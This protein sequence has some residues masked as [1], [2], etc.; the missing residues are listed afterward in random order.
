MS[1]DPKRPERVKRFK[2]I[3]LIEAPSYGEHIN[4]VG[5]ILSLVGLLMRVMLYIVL[6]CIHIYILSIVYRLNGL[7]GLE[8]IVLSFIWLMLVQLMTGN[9]R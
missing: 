8:S 6:H 5:M 7:L 3:D 2:Q 4:A 9:R 1:S